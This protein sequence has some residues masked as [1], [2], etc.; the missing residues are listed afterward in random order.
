MSQQSAGAAKL[1]A[2]M[3]NYRRG[4]DRNG[5]SSF[6]RRQELALVQSHWQV[7]MP[8]QALYSECCLFPSQF[9]DD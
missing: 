6:F 1:P 7:V 3:F 9:S 8:Q 5:V 4:Q 2:S